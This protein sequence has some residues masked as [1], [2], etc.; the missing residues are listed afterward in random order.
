M[1]PPTLSRPATRRNIKVTEHARPGLPRPFSFTRYPRNLVTHPAHDNPLPAPFIVYAGIDEAGYGPLLGP[2]CIAC[3][4]FAIHAEHINNNNP[5]HTPDLWQHLA[6]HVHR[7]RA[8]WKRAASRGIVIADSKHAKLANDSKSL[9]PLAHLER[10]VLAVLKPLGHTPSNDQQLLDT[11]T[12]SAPTAPWY[13]QQWGIDLP[14]STTPDHQS[15]LAA[16]LARAM[17]D[18]RV[19]PLDLHA[20]AIP[21][22]DFNARV[23]TLGSKA[24]LNLSAACLLLD[25]V[26]RSHAARHAWS[27]HQQPAR[28]AIDRQSGRTRYA[29][30]LAANLGNTTVRTLVESDERSVYDI[31]P[32]DDGAAPCRVSFETEAESKHLPIALASMTAKLTR[33]LLMARLNRFWIDKVPGLTPTAGYRND[34]PRFITELKAAGYERQATEMARRS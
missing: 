11:I 1:G 29:R 10:A 7:T 2:L 32:T 28:I 16:N 14:L 13:T 21:E 34:A 5:H 19:A 30:E 17:R 8:E 25:R 6:P 20:V 15:L 3:A 18:A 9:H 26:R 4:T 23:A 22:H 24:A 27:Q 33:E 12:P 31:P